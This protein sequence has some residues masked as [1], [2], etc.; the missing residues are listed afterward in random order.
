MTWTTSLTASREVIAND[1]FDLV[2]LDIGLPD[3]SG[4]DLLDDIKRQAK[5]PQVVIFSACDVSD[6]YAKAVNTV[7]LKS[8]TDSRKLADVIRHAIHPAG[9]D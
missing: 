2:L 4:L 1:S 9:E 3:G 7:L 6:K 5:P 8:E